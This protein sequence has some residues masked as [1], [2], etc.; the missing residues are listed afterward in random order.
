MD[1]AG[2]RPF[3][4]AP[5]EAHPRARS[6][7]KIIPLHVAVKGR[8]R[9]SVS[10]LKR[11][12][13]L[14]A[15]L[16]SRLNA[17][18][19]IRSVSASTW[20]GNIVVA[21]DPELG[22]ER[23]V[24]AVET[25][26]A[27]ESQRLS[28]AD[29]PS[30]SRLLNGDAS[31]IRTLKTPVAARNRSSAATAVSAVVPLSARVRAPMSAPAPS[32]MIEQPWH[33]LEARRVLE[34]LGSS[35]RIG[36]S[37]SAAQQRLRQYGYNVVS[38]PQP[39]SGL[40]VLIDQF[41]SLPV[42]LLG[43][44][45]VLSLFTGG[46]VDAAVI[47]G[48]V[49]INACIGYATERGADRAIRSISGTG[50]MTALVLRDGT[51]QPVDAAQVAVGDVLK[52]VPGNF[53]PA[54]ARIIES[55]D[56]TID[57]SALTGE[58]VPVRKTADPLSEASISLADRFN[59]VYRGTAASGG[60]GAAVVVGTGKMTEIGKIETLL[61]ETRAPPTPMQRQLEKVGTQL[62]WL[63]SAVCGGVLALGLAR[64]FGLIPM[65]KTSVS[66]AVAAIPEGLPT[67]AISTLA[68]GLANMRR[69]KVLIRRLD[70]VETL[71][72][73]KVICFDK[74]GTLTLNRMS[75]VAVQCGN[76]RYQI[77]DQKLSLDDKVIDPFE[78]PELMRLIQVLVLCNE[79]K[80]GRRQGHYQLE[81]SPTESALISLA[82]EAGI[83]PEELRRNF[84]LLVVN[85]RT[86]ERR[87]MTSVHARADG[88]RL[89]AVKG[90][91]QEVLALCR[92]HQNGDQRQ[93]LSDADRI[94][95]TRQNE[96]MA[97]AGLRVLG[98]ACG[99]AEGETNGL[100][101]ELI[102]L[103]MV[104]MADP[105][106]PAIKKVVADF[107]R[108]N[109]DT[110]MITGDQSATA[111]SIARQIG[112]SK[113]QPIKVLDSAH[114]AKLEPNVL[115][116]LAKQTHVFARVS[117]ADKLHIVRAFQ[118]GGQ[119]VAM[120]G[121]GINDGPALKAADIGV[122]M[123]RGASEVAHDVSDVI[124]ED[125]ELST[126]VAAV[127]QGRTIYGNIRKA[128]RFL[129][130]SNP[131]EVLTVLVGTSIGAGQ[132]LTAMQLLWINLMTDVFPALALALEP[133]EPDIM[134]MAPRDPLEPIVTLADFGTLGRQ[135][136]VISAG[137]LSAYGYGLSRY[138]P[139]RQASTMAFSS[140]ITA[141]LMHA[142]T[143]RS[144]T[145]SIF[146]KEKLAPNKYLQVA[147]LASFGVQI[148]ATLAPPLRGLLGLVPI[149]LGDGLVTAAGGLVPFL[150]NEAMKHSPSVVRPERG[151]R[152]TSEHRSEIRVRAP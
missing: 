81:G 47:M 108:A 69:Q 124:L 8:A 121:D 54:D 19:G 65:I 104:G 131:S 32:R 34:I 24:R 152:P 146:S 66:L 118:E 79:T 149:S 2:D 26:A 40:S 88:G 150:V 63:S 113:G 60:S 12:E 38:K 130:S 137:S 5:I 11:C 70:A 52:L 95:F 37:S 55:S 50:K 100:D 142:I 106:R 115:A 23:V 120:T 109:I 111:Y 45:S 119:V 48:V 147:L 78:Q 46:V 97:E 82:I 89:I 35:D 30:P 90:S 132:P 41:K 10:G 43:A 25:V 138:G 6:A 4:D 133:P 93:A 84:P 107:H 16:E 151:G 103:G 33:A 110:V 31:K 102:W 77:A 98:V 139:G 71:G 42:G 123:G 59:M 76:R 83:E 74:T 18:P 85:Y 128:I 64:G 61:G 94:A 136:A 143:S 68:L 144:Q 112:L 96:E 140:L 57:E 29:P 91:P 49:L 126:M 80:L 20:T 62:V 1:V 135:A 134:R 67:V 36:L 13:R 105:V 7:R 28:A 44:S 145:H 9:L 14:K 39:R 148:L 86:A 92:W 73:V 53:V 101:N 114:L 125:N 99:L 141:Q 75:A 129:L 122:A 116:A 51:V 72:S 22:V 117:P 27:R 15:A 127:R 87:F 21:F 58:S 3:G 17:L 56:L